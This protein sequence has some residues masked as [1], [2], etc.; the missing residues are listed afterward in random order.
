VTPSEKKESPFTGKSRLYSDDFTLDLNACIA[1]EL[2]VQV[3]PVDA[4]I[5]MKSPAP[6]GFSREELFLTRE[7]L[8]ENEKRYEKSWADGTVL[9]TMQNPNRK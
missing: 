9:T 6:V 7:K 4:I 8:Y 2:C 5:M 3:C 1:C